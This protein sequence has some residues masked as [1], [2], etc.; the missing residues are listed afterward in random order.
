MAPKIWRYA[1]FHSQMPFQQ[2]KS[3]LMACLQKVNFMASD[4]EML[5]SSAIQKLREFDRLRYP[6]KLL[7]VVCTTMGV[8]TRNA[9]W[10]DIRDEIP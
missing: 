1:H 9:T 7:W 10:F 8:Q 4:N 6:R 5:K 3:V 2:K